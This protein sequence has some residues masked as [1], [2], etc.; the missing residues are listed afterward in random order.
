M[1]GF[2][3]LFWAPRNTLVIT[4]TYDSLLEDGNHHLGVLDAPPTDSINEGGQGTWIP[5]IFPRCC[6]SF[7]LLCTIQ[8][9]S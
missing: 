8:V 5:Y 1:S 3:L 6:T 9:S 2:L 7:S 4:Y